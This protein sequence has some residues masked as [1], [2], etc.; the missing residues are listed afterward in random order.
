MAAM[1]RSMLNP[2]LLS[3]SPD[4]WISEAPFR[5]HAKVFCTDFVPPGR[6]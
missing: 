2:I 6:F 3:R 1:A 5:F 4:V